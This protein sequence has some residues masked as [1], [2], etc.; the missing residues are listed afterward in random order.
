MTLDKD[1]YPTVSERF[2]ELLAKEAELFTNK[3]H[4]YASGGSETGNFDRVAS[5]LTLY[6]TFPYNTRQ[7]VA[8][9]YMLKQIDAII[10]GLS[11]KITHKVEGIQ[12]RTED[13]SVY[14]KLIRIMCER[15][16]L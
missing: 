9:T 8:I 12:G 5:I 14:A 2:L 6:P 11:Q 16:E 7:G 15:D 10:W 4:D 13:V 1:Q 3:N